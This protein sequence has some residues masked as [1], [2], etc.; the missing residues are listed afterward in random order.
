MKNAIGIILTKS[1]T[2]AGIIH[3]LRI[4][5]GAFAVEKT[6]PYSRYIAGTIIKL[7]CIHI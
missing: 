2:G 5:R 6:D 7:A 3:K 1:E 4:F